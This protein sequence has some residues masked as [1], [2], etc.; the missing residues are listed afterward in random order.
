MAPSQETFNNIEL[1]LPK[2]T[3]VQLLYS[4]KLNVKSTRLKRQMNCVS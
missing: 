2:Y 1:S 3:R 4:N